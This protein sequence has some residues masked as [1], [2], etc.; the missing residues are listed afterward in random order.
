MARK[1]FVHLAMLLIIPIIVAIGA[2]ILIAVNQDSSS[3]SNPSNSIQPTTDPQKVVAAFF[4]SVTAKDKNKAK[5]FLSPNVDKVALQSTLSDSSTTPSLYTQDFSYKLTGNQTELSGKTAYVNVDIEVQGQ[6]LPT[7]VILQKE[8]N[9]TWLIT[10]SETAV[11]D[12]NGM[13][14]SEV[15]QSNSVNRVVL[16]LMGSADFYL[17][18]PEGTHAG[19]DFTTGKRINE[20]K[21]VFY[22]GRFSDKL[23]SFSIVDMEGTWELKI[24]GNGEGQYIL[25][26]QP[27]DD[28][29]SASFITGQSQKDSITTYILRYPSEKG[30]PIEVVATQ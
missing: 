27:V 26:T 23:Q 13:F 18:S 6:L 4:D 15:R 1:G 2:V 28:P 12:N 10:D 21:D 9:G 17:T 8:T 25:S 22:D 3:T 5:R 14:P 11:A 19:Y 29:S 16:V 7:L 30:K 24:I 20:I